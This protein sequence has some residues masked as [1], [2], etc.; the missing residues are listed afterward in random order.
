[1]GSLDAVKGLEIRTGGGGPRAPRFPSPPFP[2]PHISSLPH[3]HPHPPH[4]F[5][6]PVH[7]GSFMV[8][9]LPCWPLSPHRWMEVRMMFAV[10]VSECV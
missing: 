1:M 7:L 6:L 8:S 5:L 2:L 9:G 4:L 3:C 10:Q